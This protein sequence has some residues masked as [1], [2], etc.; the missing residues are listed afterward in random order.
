MMNTDPHYNATTLSLRH[1]LRE[2]I[3]NTI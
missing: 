3:D 2:K 1:T